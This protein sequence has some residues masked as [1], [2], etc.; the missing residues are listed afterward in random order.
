MFWRTRVCVCLRYQTTPAITIPEPPKHFLFLIFI[1][2]SYLTLFAILLSICFLLHYRR[3]PFHLVVTMHF[4]YSTNHGQAGVLIWCVLGPRSRGAT[5]IYHLTPRTSPAQGKRELPYLSSSP[6]EDEQHKALE[7]PRLPLTRES[8]A[9]NEHA[10]LPQPPFSFPLYNR[11]SN[12]RAS[13]PSH[14]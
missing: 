1:W 5:Q 14:L 8:R 9:T 4:T 2:R 3:V 10:I 11:K 6:R 7:W 12:A 13:R